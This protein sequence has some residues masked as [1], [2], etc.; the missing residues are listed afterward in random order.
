[1]WLAIGSLLAALLAGVQ[2]TPPAPEP[3]AA[4]QREAL[5]VIKDLFKT[6]Y[7]RRSPAEMQAFGRLLL[8]K[9][10][11]ARKDPAARFVML[12][13]ARDIAAQAGDST[14]ALAA[15]DGLAASFAVDGPAMK[16]AVLGKFATGAKDV[17]GARSVA[18]GYLAVVADAVRADNYEAASTAAGKAEAVAKA[19][20]D[21]GLLARAQAIKKDLGALQEHYLKAKPGLNVPGAPGDPEAIGRYLCFV[22]D[23]WDAGLPFL[24]GG[25]KPPLNALAESDRATPAEVERQIEVADG[26]WELGQKDKV[27]WRKARILGRSRR[28]YEAALSKAEGLALIKIQK[29]LSELEEAL[30][31]PL[32]LLPLVNLK[33]DV[34]SGEF[35]LEAG[36]LMVPSRG[37]YPRVQIPY[38]PPAEYD[39]ELLVERKEGG[40]SFNLGL[41]VGSSQAMLLVDAGDQ[42]DVCALEMIDGKNF[43]ANETA[44]KG[45]RLPLNRSVAIRCAVRAS[46]VTVTVD[47]ARVIEWKGDAKR[48]SVWSAWQVPLKNALFIGASGAGFNVSR[49]RL[50]PVS[51]QGKRLR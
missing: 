24:A 44:V 41:V 4:A 47:G 1:M 21:A 35:R 22:Q 40:N 29:R 30:P 49:L 45:K 8:E 25:A 34:V 12:R 18:R 31:G 17:E 27:S 48:L 46:G 28:W 15:V 38:A 3:D 14:T 2:S 16:L 11:E 37:D 36:V 7:A 51:G 23:D 19:A 26:W 5:G 6:E 32:A 42:G 10:E 20:Q 9:A 43:T 13:E 39:L 33:Q 50:S